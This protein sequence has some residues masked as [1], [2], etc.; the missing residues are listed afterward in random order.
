MLR[1]HWNRRN[2]LLSP[3]PLLLCNREHHAYESYLTIR[4]LRNKIVNKSVHASTLE[5]NVHDSQLG[6]LQLCIVV[7]L[8]YDFFLYTIFYF[9]LINLTAHHLQ[10]H[11]F[12]P[13]KKC[14]T[15]TILKDFKINSNF[16]PKGIWLQHL[17]CKYARQNN[18]IS[19]RVSCN[20]L[21]TRTYVVE[22]VRT[23]AKWRGKWFSN[24]RSQKRSVWV[25]FC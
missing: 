11:H 1:I 17:F 21:T 6:N 18:F 9:L 20:I 10:H 12:H 2:W 16:F 14:I 22:I 23:E 24:S 13:P 5:K 19:R 8:S 3:P 25:D 15:E 7:F 4:E